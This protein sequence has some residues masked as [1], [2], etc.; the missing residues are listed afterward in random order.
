M[1]DPSLILPGMSLLRMIQT[2][3]QFNTSYAM[4]YFSMEELGKL[5]LNTELPCNA[6]SLLANTAGYHLLTFANS[7]YQSRFSYNLYNT[8]IKGM[9]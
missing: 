7:H 4:K 1:H 6:I 8:L 9:H 2:I 3:Y 5:H